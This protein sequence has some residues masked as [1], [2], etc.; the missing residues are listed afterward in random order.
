MLM[1]AQPCG[2]PHNISLL[3]STYCGVCIEA[4]DHVE[5]LSKDNECIVLMFCCRVLLSCSVVVAIFFVAT[6][7]ICLHD[8][9]LI[10]TC[11]EST[12]GVEGGAPGQRTWHT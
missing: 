7:M 3:H 8:V 6:D 5:Q 12:H 4:K 11:M 10:Y 1:M 2:T 9:S